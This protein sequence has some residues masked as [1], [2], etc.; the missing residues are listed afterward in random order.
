VHT[1]EICVAV[2]RHAELLHLAADRRLPVRV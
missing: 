1:D 2:V